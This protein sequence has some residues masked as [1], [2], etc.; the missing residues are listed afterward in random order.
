M[1]QFVLSVNL[2]TQKDII[3]RTLGHKLCKIEILGQ[4]GHKIQFLDLFRKFLGH[5]NSLAKCCYNL[6][7]KMDNSDAGE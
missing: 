4:M 1:L 5:L 3:P 6:V 7:V 2:G